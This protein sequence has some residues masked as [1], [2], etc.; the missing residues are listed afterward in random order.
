MCETEKIVRY[1]IEQERRDREADTRNLR[2]NILFPLTIFALGC[3]LNIL[4]GRET[5]GSIFLG[6]LLLCLAIKILFD[7]TKVYSFDADE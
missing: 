6:V 3:A 2:F 5:A 1:S 4:F 7:I